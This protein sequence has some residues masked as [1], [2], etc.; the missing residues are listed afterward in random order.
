MEPEKAGHVV[1]EPYRLEGF[2]A[3]LRGRRLFVVGVDAGL[4]RFAALE[5]ESLYRGK[6]VLV[7]GDM[8]GAA[9]AHV[10][11]AIWRR[12]WDVIFRMRD[13][14]D[15]Q[16]IATYVANAAKPVRVFWLGGDIPRT[17][18]SRWVKQ[19]VTLVGCSETGVVGVTEWEAIF[20]SHGCE[21]GI[22]ERVL[23][24]RGVGSSLTQVREHMSELTASG[25]ALVWSNIDEAGGRGS[26]YWYD[27]E[28]VA[29]VGTGLVRTEIVQMLDAIKKWTETGK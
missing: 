5:S 15:A 17:L 10:P 16:M 21:M 6:N 8:G 25:A 28:S 29:E 13:S 14:F 9:A 22:V 3:G 7:I 1:M 2:D 27:P 4:R 19:D 18:W 24:Q 23:G 26:L 12:K 11:L 20:F